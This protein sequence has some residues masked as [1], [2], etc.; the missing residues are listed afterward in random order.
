M[1][2][3][4]VEF[5]DGDGDAHHDGHPHLCARGG[6]YFYRDAALC[7]LTKHVTLS[8]LLLVVSKQ[9]LRQGVRVW[10]HVL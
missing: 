5:R 4:G 7:G 10:N 1:G 9:I 6:D 8:P 2:V 3:D